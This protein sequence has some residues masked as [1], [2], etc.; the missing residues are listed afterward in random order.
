MV[1]N[2][3]FEASGRNKESVKVAGLT[4]SSGKLSREHLFRVVR[5]EEILADGLRAS[6]MRR[7]KD[8]VSEVT[9][10]KVSHFPRLVQGL[11][12]RKG[13]MEARERCTMASVAAGKKMVLPLLPPCFY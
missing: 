12:E 6:S 13:R 4:V 7:F 11:K 8:K 2:K 1:N 9:K 10:D 5:D 3:V